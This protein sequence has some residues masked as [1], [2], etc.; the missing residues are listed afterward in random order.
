MHRHRY[1]K[2][3]T[4]ALATAIVLAS[5]FAQAG[6]GL[7][8]GLVKLSCEAILCLSTGAPPNACAPSLNHYFSIDFDDFSDTIDARVD[9][10]KLCPVAAETPP[11][12]ALVQA[13]AHGAGRCDAASLNATLLSYTG[14]GMGSIGQGCITGTKPAYC[15]AYEGHEYTD[16]NGG[17]QYIIDPPKQV[18]FWSFQ[19][20]AGGND[21]GRI[22]NISLGGNYNT[23]QTCGHWV[24]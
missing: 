20:I 2:I 21:I 11:M 6:E 1:L 19:G 17:A 16:L 15:S 23:P 5:P 12:Q 14:G 10:L 7:L 18:G 22:G 4:L 13:I 9:F 8:T 3:P 24:D